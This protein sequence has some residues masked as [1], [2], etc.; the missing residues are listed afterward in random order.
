[1][2]VTIIPVGMLGT[3]CYLLYSDKN[4]CAIIDP[5]AQAEKI[6]DIIAAKNLIPRYILLTHGHYDHIGGVKRLMEKYPEAGL[7]VGEEDIEL[8]TD[9]ERNYVSN[10]GLDRDAF[11]IPG[12]K[13][14]KEGDILELDDLRVGVLETPGHTKG[15]VCYLCGDI[16]FSGDTL[17]YENCGRC[18]LYGGDFEVIKRSLSRLAGLEGDYTVYPGHGESTTMDHERGHNPYINLKA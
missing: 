15:G 6:A 1:M 14:A 17:F 13:A 10:R 7:Y 2:H 4:S 11:Y 18:D 5:G 9:P 16:V 8:I 12:A 3:N